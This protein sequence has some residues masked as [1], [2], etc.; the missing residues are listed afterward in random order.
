VLLA[1]WQTHLRTV[2]LI[3]AIALVGGGLGTL[4][5]PAFQGM[6]A[7]TIPKNRL[8]SAVAINSRLLQLARFLGPRSRGS[9]SPVGAQ[10]AGESL[11]AAD[12]VKV[13]VTEDD[14]LDVARGELQAPPRRRSAGVGAEAPRRRFPCGQAASG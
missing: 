8:E 7:S 10:L 11:H 12:M 3:G 6:L 9:C 4:R 13:A 1:V 2:P 14:R 5:F